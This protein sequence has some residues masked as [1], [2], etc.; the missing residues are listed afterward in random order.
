MT[1]LPAELRGIYPT[2]LNKHNAPIAARGECMKWL[3]F[4]WDFCLKYAHRPEA[5]SSLSLFWIN[6]RQRDKVRVNKR[7][8]RG[9]STSILRKPAV[10]RRLRRCQ[11][12][13][14]VRQSGRNQV[15]PPLRTENHGNISFRSWPTPSSASNTRARHWRPI[16]IGFNDSRHLP[17]VNLRQR[18]ATKTSR[19][20]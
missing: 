15:E 11:P 8:R 5:E 20:F 9:R 10:R 4:Y 19:R 17:G 18:W 14:R 6:S 2:W 1:H 13:C 7:E 3:R 12:H 16:G